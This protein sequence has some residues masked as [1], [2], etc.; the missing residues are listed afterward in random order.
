MEP[1]V[2]STFFNAGNFSVSR[3]NITVSAFVFLSW[4][5]LWGF[6][7]IKYAESNFLLYLIAFISLVCL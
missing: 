4:V 7:A 6:S 3:I 2:K 1:V 5:S